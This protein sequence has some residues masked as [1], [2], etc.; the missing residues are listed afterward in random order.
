VLNYLFYNFSSDFSSKFLYIV[1]ASI[2]AGSIIKDDHSSS[3]GAGGT[4]S[5]SSSMSSS[6]EGIRKKQTRIIHFLFF[7]LL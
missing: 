4:K 7:I 6:E 1:L 2:G 5:K 3:S